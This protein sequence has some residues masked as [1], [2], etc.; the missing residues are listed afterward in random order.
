MPIVRLLGKTGFDPETT[1]ILASAFD[2]AWQALTISGSTFLVN[3]RRAKTRKVL[4]KR[5][6]EMGRRG[7]RDSDRL[8]DDAL[9][10]LVRFKLR[11]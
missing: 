2:A 11:R 10:H 4:S 5:I 3:P 7:E 8:A 6:I 9:A 1:K